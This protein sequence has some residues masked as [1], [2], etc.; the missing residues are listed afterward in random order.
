MS[1]QLLQQI[2]SQLA[3][4]SDSVEELKASQ[5]KL[6]SANQELKDGQE[7]LAKKVALLGVRIE[8]EVIDKVNAL[9]DARSVYLDYFAS[10]K[11][12]L[13]KIEQKV[14]YITH[15]NIEAIVKLEEHDRELRLLR[16]ERQ[17]S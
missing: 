5:E 4:L 1:E 3:A 14:E 8:N 17:S 9:F 10:I 16:L 2:I 6:V 15:K 11:N 7:D 13:A 12:T